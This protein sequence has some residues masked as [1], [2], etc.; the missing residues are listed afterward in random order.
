MR[1]FSNLKIAVKLMLAFFIIAAIAGGVGVFGI[2]SLSDVNTSNQ[3]MFEERGNSQGYLGYVFGYFQQQRVFLR[4][5]NIY[6]TVE[7]AQVAKESAAAVDEKMMANLDAYGRACNTEKDI[8][9]YTEL[10]KRIEDFRGLRDELMSHAVAGDFEQYFAISQEDR[11]AA[12]IIGATNAVDEAVAFNLEEANVKM[13]EQTQKVSMTVYIMIAL[14]AAA[15]I[16]AVLLGMIISRMISKSVKATADQL[17]KMARGDELEEIELKKF[18][19]EFKLMAQNLNDVR[20]SLYLLLDDTGKLAE[21]AAEGNLSTRAN[22][23]LHQGGYRTIIEGVNNTLDAVM[24][25]INE[26]ATVLE[27]MS[28]G[29][30]GVRVEGDYKGDHAVIKDAV[31]K[32]IGAIKGYISEIAEVL[33]EMSSGNLGVEIKSEYLGD[34]VALKEALN[35]IVASLNKVLSDIN[36]AADQVAAGT[37]QVSDGNQEIS[38]G[39]AEQASSIEQLTSAITQIAEQTRQNAMSAGQASEVSTTAKDNAVAGNEQMN[40]L[41]Q[42]MEEINESS[43]NISRIIKVIDDIAFQTNI[44]AL[45]AAVEAARAGVHGKGFA[46]VAEEVRNLAARSAGAAKETTELIEG[47][48][49]KTEAGT[50]IADETAKALD[51]IVEGVQNA[52]TLVTEIASASNQ[53]AAA[54]SEVNK[55]IEQMSQVVQTNSATS[56]EAAAAAEELSSQAELL[57][58]L[59]AQFRLRENETMAALRSENPAPAAVKRKEAMVKIELDDENFGKY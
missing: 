24:E 17:A 4:D 30:L 29:N 9:I 31:N 51:S 36:T 49:K 15:V 11:S 12:I 48:I 19:G 40:M 18:S 56:E 10:A 3:Q 28:K 16:L 13:E 57:K 1:W 22:A 7:R 53:Q 34:F 52:V 32:T 41:Q 37:S 2:L 46:V 8:A 43:A 27:E 39:A 33:G 20:S 58:S 42:A 21:A 14:V 23:Q 45:N 5:I 6:Q 25:P 26:A 55:G 38:Q 35:G 50:K 59:V 44:L 54:I 47:S